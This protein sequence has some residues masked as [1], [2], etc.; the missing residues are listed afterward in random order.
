MPT[1]HYMPPYEEDIS[2]RPFRVAFSYA[3]QKPANVE[4]VR[5]AYLK[6]RESKTVS[7][8]EI[9][10]DSR[11]RLAYLDLDKLL[12]DIYMRADVVVVFACAGYDQSP[13]CARE[14]EAIERRVRRRDRGV[15]L[16]QLDDTSLESLGVGLAGHLDVRTKSEFA[17]ARE[18]VSEIKARLADIS[19][20]KQRWKRRDPEPAASAEQG[21]RANPPR[22]LFLDA[23]GHWQ[24]GLQLLASTNDLEIAIEPWEM[25]GAQLPAFQLI[26]DEHY[27]LAPYEIGQKVYLPDEWL[28]VFVAPVT[29]AAKWRKSYSLDVLGPAFATRSDV[30]AYVPREQT[31]VGLPRIGVI[32]DEITSTV[33]LQM[34]LC[35]G[36]KYFH[37]REKRLDLKL[38]NNFQL[39]T[40][41]QPAFR[42]RRLAGPKDAADRFD[43]CILTRRE[44]R[45]LLLNKRIPNTVMRVIDVD[46]AVADFLG[47]DAVPRSV[48]CVHQEQS[49]NPDLMT[50]FREW[51]E[52]R[53]Q[54]L[55]SWTATDGVTILDP[56]GP[57]ERNAQKTLVKHAI[58]FKTLRCLPLEYA[59]NGL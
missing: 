9:F 18:I 34:L 49:H 35:L 29:L 8:S 59:D 25:R 7:D 21:E 13:W 15:I 11:Y 22:V 32:D 37:P 19:N 30:C 17:A 6:L 10:Y 52:N 48:Y 20:K 4:K 33:M 57:E 14:W 55:S 3:G 39:L 41:H 23:F 31:H 50:P 27:R 5:K 54:S 12:M 44:E 43:A 26:P 36:G 53:V 51:L 42:M 56:W 46:P 16:V 40:E 58:D 38:L 45:Q 47:V 1:A 2:T 24:K 28:F